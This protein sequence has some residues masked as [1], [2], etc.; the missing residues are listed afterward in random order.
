MEKE[1][2]GLAEA[3][4]LISQL[5]IRAMPLQ[6]VAEASTKKETVFI[7][8]DGK[9][10]VVKHQ[11]GVGLEHVVLTFTDLARLIFHDME[12]STPEQ[13][14][15][16][17][18]FINYN[19]LGVN[20]KYYYEEGQK[21]FAALSILGSEAAM[22]LFSLCSPDYSKSFLSTED[23]HFMLRTVFRDAVTDASL[24]DAVGNLAFVTSDSSNINV[25]SITANT[26]G[27]TINQSVAAE[28]AIPQGT[29][30]FDV[31]PYIGCG[32]TF[33]VR[34]LCEPD[35]KRKAWL[36]CPYKDSVE[37]YIK[38]VRE[39]A[40]DIMSDQLHFFGIGIVDPIPVKSPEP[41]PR[42]LRVVIGTP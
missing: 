19:A 18:L 10:L 2:Q 8:N 11:A 24:L 23:L 35:L 27:R 22:K 14:T 41:L 3:I 20:A 7:G 29:Q 34:V 12:N 40:F 21:E 28:V 4:A 1:G 36:F 30:A 26:Y 31:T 16:K 6:N 17:L 9:P 13:N 39:Y 42:T 25:K 32:K 37:E 38:A 5:A 33:R 15:K